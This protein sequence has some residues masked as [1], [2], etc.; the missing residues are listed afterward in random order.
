MLQTGI[1]C[2]WKYACPGIS[3]L[4]KNIRLDSQDLPETSKRNSRY[5]LDNKKATLPS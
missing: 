4:E 2:I 5:T 3:L 1:T